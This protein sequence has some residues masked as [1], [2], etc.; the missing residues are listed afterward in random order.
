MSERSRLP[1]SNRHHTHAE[2]PARRA[3][4]FA[5]HDAGAPLA[6]HTRQRMET[7]FGH[8]FADVRVHD[9]PD[10]SRATEEVDARAFTVG[11]DIVFRA[12]TLAPETD[13]GDRLLAHEL[14]HAVQNSRAMPRADAPL[15]DDGVEPGETEARSASSVAGSRI[16]P[17]VHS[18]P[19]AVIARSPQK[20]EERSGVFGGI[21]SL[22][23]LGESVI[24]SGA[25]KEWTKAASNTDV[26]RKGAKN[27]GML[28]SYS[29]V[30]GV[31]NGGSEIYDGLKKGGVEG[32]VDAGK[33]LL[34]VVSSY[35]GVLGHG[36]TE[37]YAGMASG[38]IDMARGAYSA[39]TSDD[40]DVATKGAYTAAGGLANTVTGLG[41]A[42]GN[43]FLMG[44]GRAFGAGLWGGEKLVNWTDAG[45][46]RRGDYGRDA[47]GQNL[48]GSQAAADDGLAWRDGT[49]EMWSDLG[50]P[51]W[52]ARAAGGVAGGGAT[53]LKSWYNA[54]RGTVNNVGEKI[55][56]TWSLDPDEIDWGKTAN[57]L[58][59]FD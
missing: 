17:F 47:Y 58:R 24:E 55:S 3:L 56:D 48:T 10:A 40:I 57:P 1:V 43:P 16:A 7:R 8:D 6:A 5:D 9:G 36:P 53:I 11:Q 46:Q 20:D 34:D 37:G 42:T 23:G 21:S 4:G 50:A 32:G 22:F 26:I 19:P 25:I 41:D 15:V 33:G 14:T 31:Y 12:G 39:V 44:G 45:A 49:R 59:W 35:G 13:A 29:D 27:A 28:G 30:F 51:S 2:A 18:A 54:G 52:M 38:G